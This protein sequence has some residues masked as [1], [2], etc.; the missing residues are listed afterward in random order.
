VSNLGVDVIQGRGSAV[1][2]TPEVGLLLL[3]VDWAWCGVD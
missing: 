3:V 1:F 2:H